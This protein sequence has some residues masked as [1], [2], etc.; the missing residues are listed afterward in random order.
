MA[1]WLGP[2]G[3]VLVGGIGSLLVALIGSRVFSEL[4]RTESPE[5]AVSL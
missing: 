1:A 3:A 5:T 2:V 4:A